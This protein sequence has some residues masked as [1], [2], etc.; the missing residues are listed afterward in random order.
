VVVAVACG[1]VVDS[2]V[3]VDGSSRRQATRARMRQDA[4][5]VRLESM[6]TTPFRSGDPARE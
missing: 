5:S 2:V 6:T 4:A 1:A 3:S